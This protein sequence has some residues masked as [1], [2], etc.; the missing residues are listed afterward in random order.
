MSENNLQDI[1]QYRMQMAAICTAAI[2]YWKEGDS[3]HPDYDT[4]ALRDVARLYAKYAEARALTS[5]SDAPEGCVY[6]KTE[7]LAEYNLLKQEKLRA[8]SDALGE[9]SDE[10]RKLS[11][12][13]DILVRLHGEDARV[14]ALRA[15][16][17][18]RYAA[19]APVAAPASGE[20]GAEPDTSQDW[21]KLDG[22]VAYHL[23]DRHGEDWADIGRKME[24]WGKAR[25]ASPIADHMEQ[26]RGMVGQRAEVA[27]IAAVLLDAWQRAEP[28]HPVTQYPESYKATFADMARAVLAAAP[29]AESLQGD[30]ATDSGPLI[31]EG[32]KQAARQ[33][34]T[35]PAAGADGENHG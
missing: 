13:R 7:L 26:A 14:T 19:P 8:G 24:A 22:A 17:A 21:A 32:T 5:G 23:I 11:D 18:I 2:G 28:E 29:L 31:D 16:D 1:E 35:P 30:A 33:C 4:L 12:V 9:L 15:I 3:I 6:V 25:Y 20:A 34:P 10:G 27:R